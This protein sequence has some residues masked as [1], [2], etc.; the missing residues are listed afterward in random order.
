MLST[1]V[2]NLTAE[3]AKTFQQVPALLAELASRKV[4]FYERTGTTFNHEM[5]KTVLLNIVDEETR[6]KI[7]PFIGV[8][9]ATQLTNRK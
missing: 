3:R 5:E 9:S 6:E 1:Q 2:L 4:T 7:L 8:E